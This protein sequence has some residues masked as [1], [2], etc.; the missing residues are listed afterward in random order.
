MK[1][2]LFVLFIVLIIS[3]ACAPAAPAAAPAATPTATPSAAP[4]TPPTPPEAAKSL[5]PEELAASFN[6]PYVALFTVLPPNTIS[7]YPAVL[8]WDVKN[9]TGVIIEP[10]I[11]VVDAAGS[12]DIMTPVMTTVYQLKATNAQGAILATTT[13]TIS[14]ELPRRDAPV[15]KQ[16][17][18]NP[19]II[20]KGETSTLVWMTIAAS[21]VTF[22]GKTV[23]GEGNTQVSPTE[24]TTYTLVATSSDGTQ[25]QSVTVN[26]K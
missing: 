23:P 3:L 8:K 16:F 26:V 14:G 13:L 24:T 22:E 2:V 7:N 18:A 25:Y 15:I 9:S 19:H 10:N 4:S 11:G 1:K 5:T 6:L 21:A 20:K 17:T 12:K